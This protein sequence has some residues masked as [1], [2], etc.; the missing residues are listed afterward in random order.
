MQTETAEGVTKVY[1]AAVEEALKRRLPE[2][3]EGDLEALVGELVAMPARVGLTR[4]A[5][6]RRVGKIPAAPAP[7][8]TADPRREHLSGALA[9][10]EVLE[11]AGLEERLAGIAGAGLRSARAL[12]EQL[13]KEARS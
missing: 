7:V 8:V 9:A 3:P 11:A 6:R 10:L 5:A 1:A 2:L 12:A 13:E 4:R